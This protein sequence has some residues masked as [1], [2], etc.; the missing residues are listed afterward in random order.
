MGDSFVILNGQAILKENA[1][2]SIF[3]KAMFFD[4]AVY[5]SLKIIKGT[6]FFPQF[7]AERLL[8][9]AK[10]IGIK[11]DFTKDFIIDSYNLLIE[12]NN[13]QNGT[14]RVLFLGAGDETEIPRLYMFPLGLTFYPDKFYSNG[15]KVITFEGERN[16]P[17]SK[18]KDLT[19][20]FVAYREAKNKEALDALLIDRDGFIRE[21]TRTNFFAVKDGKIHTAPLADV[22]EGITRKILVKLAREN[23]IEIVEEK[24]DPKKIN[25]YQEFFITSTS[26]NVMPIVKIN[27]NIVS[28][29]V[30][31][32]T[33]KMI[34]LFREYYNREVFEENSK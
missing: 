10:L 30:G 31:P 33:K 32:I 14:A 17:Q 16:F 4:F 24:V 3:D 15:V 2:I 27:D 7:H 13:I 20:S 12:K 21:G 25:E 28:K 29:E 23:D 11:H 19:L 34:K 5:D 6:P 1:N 22:L 26:M 18:T 8:E 9:S